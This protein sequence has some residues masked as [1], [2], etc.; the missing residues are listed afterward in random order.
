[1]AS[2]ALILTSG[3]VSLSSMI[4]AGKKERRIENHRHIDEEHEHIPTFFCVETSV[5]LPC[6]LQMFYF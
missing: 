2:A 3:D 4:K 6:L 1:M 5:I